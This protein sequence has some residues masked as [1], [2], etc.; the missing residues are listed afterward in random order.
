MYAVKFL[1]FSSEPEWK[2][3]RKLILPEEQQDGTIHYSLYDKYWP[4]PHPAD[5]E[6]RVW[7]LAIPKDIYVNLPEKNNDPS[8]KPSAE[9]LTTIPGSVHF[10]ANSMP[11]NLVDIA[12][13]IPEM[14]LVTVKQNKKFVEEK[15]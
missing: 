9:N 3:G 5:P 14:T 6:L 8:K 7:K 13:N 1:F 12:L 11:N 4:N 2:Y 10:R 15:N